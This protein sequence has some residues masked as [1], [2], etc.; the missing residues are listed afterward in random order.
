[1]P[2]NRFE[3]LVIQD[4]TLDYKKK[5]VLHGV[6]MAI[7]TNEI[8]CLL[9]PNGAGKSSLFN[10]LIGFLQPK[11][12]TIS[13]DQIDI[14]AFSTQQRT[15]LGLS[16]LP[17][18]ACIYQGLSIK[19]N[20][21]SVLEMFETNPK[22]RALKLEKI[23]HDFQLTSIADH[24]GHE[25]SGGQRRRTEIARCMATQPKIILLDE[26]F[27]G[28]DPIAIGQIQ[29]LIL[30]LKQQGIGTLI[31]DHQAHITLKFTDQAHVMVDGHV[32]VSGASR[33]IAC[34]P[35][36]KACYLGE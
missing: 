28:I 19:D 36:V 2:A 14:T 35:D 30:Q 10:I 27:A 5:T 17:Q 24:M 6:N 33:E 18:Q 26:P 20:V 3:A 11:S 1:M 9:G 16:F 31:T 29:K 12:G 7:N 8:T 34:H 4:V 25:V 22:K 23:L 15:K 32:M 13:L 21:L